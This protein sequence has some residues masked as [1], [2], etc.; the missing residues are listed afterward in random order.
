M[1]KKAFRI[2]LISAVTVT[3]LFLLAACR[4]ITPAQTEEATTKADGF[5]YTFSPN[6]YEFDTADIPAPVSVEWDGKKVTL[7]CDV[8]TDIRWSDDTPLYFF[9]GYAVFPDY[10]NYYDKL[11]EGITVE[12]NAIDTKGNRAFDCT[13]PEMTHFTSNGNTIVKTNDGK[14]L[15]VNPNECVSTDSDKKTYLFVQE[16][17]YKLTQYV[18]GFK[19]YK[20]EETL[21]SIGN[22]YNGLVPYIVKS[23]D[24]SRYSGRL[25]LMDTEGN[26]VIEPIYKTNIPE[27]SFAF[28]YDSRIIIE[29]NGRIAILKLTMEEIPEVADMTEIT[30]EKQAASLTCH[31]VE[32]VMEKAWLENGYEYTYL[33]AVH[34]LST[35]AIYRND[36]FHPYR[37]SVT[38]VLEN[39]HYLERFELDEIERVLFEVLGEVDLFPIN[40]SSRE[41]TITDE[42]LFM[43]HERGGYTTGYTA[44][45]ITAHTDGDLVRVTC[46]LEAFDGNTDKTNSCGEYEFIYNRLSDGEREYLRLVDITNK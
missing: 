11:D 9:N 26:V 13:Y 44:K 45:D 16:T 12:Y 10:G 1:L 30:P 21:I 3:T 29:F 27:Y 33:D 17:T 40:D 35:L 41:F 6:D 4:V 42:H 22:V 5:E 23:E 46:I 36:A 25:G 28:G 38:L 39:N 18:E 20:G 2:V 37:S 19:K 7:E 15:S 14:Y 24:D 34:F 8:I 31:L 43:Q 32:N